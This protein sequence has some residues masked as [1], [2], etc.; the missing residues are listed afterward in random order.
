[1]KTPD[2]I[3]RWPGYLN[4]CLAQLCMGPAK[5][6]TGSFN[7]VSS[8]I[9]FHKLNPPL[10]TGLMRGLFSIWCGSGLYLLH[11]AAPDGP[12]VA[13][14]VGACKAKQADKRQ[15]GRISSKIF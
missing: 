15:S 14:R 3:P 9:A 1:M 4:K 11:A 10:N 5:N 13:E 8:D 7:R 2:S 12:S 6:L